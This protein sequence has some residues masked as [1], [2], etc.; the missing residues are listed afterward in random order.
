MSKVFS[1]LATSA[2]GYITGRDP[3]PGHGLG[4]GGVL[5]DWYSDP[6]NAAVYQ[7]LVDRVGAV[8]TGRT[9]YDDSEGFDGGG[10]HPSAPMVVV[11]HRP[12]PAEYADSGTQHFAGSIESAIEQARKLAGDK[13]VAIQGG[14]TL[15]AAIAAGLVDEVVIHQ[16]PV[17][18]GGGRRLFHDLPGQT[19]LA[20]IE[21]TP[22]A[23]VLHLRYRIEK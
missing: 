23:G 21:A 8:V 20:L 16:V 22:A 1:A 12:A 5:F 4:D 14:V 7:G 9:T 18:L 13:E 17:L 3:R 10:P 11:T 2:D 6:R 15:T 19:R